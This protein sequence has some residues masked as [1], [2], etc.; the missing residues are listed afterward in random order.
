[1]PPWLPASPAVVMLRMPST[2]EIGSDGIG[3]GLQR[4]GAI[5]TSTSRAGAVRQNPAS[6]FRNS[7]QCATVGRMR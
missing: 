6:T 4:K 1:M 3:I 2:K 5:G 7:F